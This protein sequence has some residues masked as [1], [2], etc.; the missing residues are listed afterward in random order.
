[1]RGTASWNLCTKNQMQLGNWRVKE[2]NEQMGRRG[3]VVSNNFCD[4]E[5]SAATATVYAWHPESHIIN[6]Y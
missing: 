5:S 4:S 6:L 2:L 3:S 1:M